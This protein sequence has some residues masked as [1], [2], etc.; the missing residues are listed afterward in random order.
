MKPTR[1]VYIRV[2]MTEEEKRKINDAAF[3]IGETL[4][5]FVRRTMLL[6]A[7]NHAGGQK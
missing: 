1:E 6:A 4:S 5:S 3:A 7:K 2:M